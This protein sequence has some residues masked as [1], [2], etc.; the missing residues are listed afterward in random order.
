M[1][2]RK[3]AAQCFRQIQN[4]KHGRIFTEWLFRELGYGQPLANS[5]PRKQERNVALHDLAVDLE[6]MLK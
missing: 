5:D 3:E 2:E 4:N 1:I 6:E